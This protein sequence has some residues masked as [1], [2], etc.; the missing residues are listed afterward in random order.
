MI[1]TF[2]GFSLVI[3]LLKLF[4]TKTAQELCRVPERK[5]AELLFIEKIY[6]LDMLRSGM[7]VQAWDYSAVAHEFNANGS[8]MSIK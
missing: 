1:F 4:P 3:S 7:R 5:K 2:G 6:G 8:T